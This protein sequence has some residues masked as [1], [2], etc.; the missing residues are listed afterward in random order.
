LLHL[1]NK[2]REN[3]WSQQRDLAC[4]IWYLALWENSKELRQKSQNQTF[5]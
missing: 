3:F 5:R 1:K 4:V 2:K